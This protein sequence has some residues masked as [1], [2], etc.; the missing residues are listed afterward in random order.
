MK[1]ENNK[2]NWKSETAVPQCN[3]GQCEKISATILFLFA[4][5]VILHIRDH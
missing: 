4:E 2:L 3:K 1:D 5:N